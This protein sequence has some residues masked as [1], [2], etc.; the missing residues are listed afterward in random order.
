MAG[1]K[2]VAELCGV[3]IKTVSNVINKHP[4]I[5]EETR[6][7]VLAA[8]KQCGYVPNI[9][10]RSLVMKSN[11]PISQLGY[12][13]GIVMLPGSRKY[14]DSY[15]V[16]LLKGIEDEIRRQGH[17][18]VFIENLA[19]LESDVVRL[20]YFL[21][22]ENIDGIV[23]FAGAD[24][25]VFPQIQ[26]F[27]LVMIGQHAGYDCVTSSKAEGISM[28]MK[29]LFEKGHRNIGFCGGDNDPRFSTYVSELNRR[30][31][32]CKKEW[33]FNVGYGFESGF[34]GGEIFASLSKR[35]SA[36]VCGSDMTAIGF[37]HSVYDRGLKIPDDVSIT[38]YDG[39]AEAALVYPPLTTVN[40]DKEGIG[41][42]A[43]RALI[44]KIKNPG[45]EICCRTLS[46]ELVIGKSVAQV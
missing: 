33:I 17:Q 1:M 35:P 28:V 27:P 41:R 30:D 23:S 31:L 15:M 44:D 20:N 11:A 46:V 39:T 2:E 37:M 24:C 36:V 5:K 14:Q 25:G 3:S 29:M 12:R 16:A 13:I 42:V 8:I 45:R 38:G 22:P 19:D 18:T 21:S 43:V 34:K 26:K 4:N 32:P 9:Q 7:K 40:A 6:E 10:A